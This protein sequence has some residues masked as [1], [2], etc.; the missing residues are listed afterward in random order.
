[1]SSVLFRI[2]TYKE[3]RLVDTSALRNRLKEAPVVPLVQ[4]DNPETAVKI[5]N[6][7]VAGGLTVIEV[8]LRTSAALECLKEN[9]DAALDLLAKAIELNAENQ[10]HAYHDPDF[11]FLRDDPEHAALFVAE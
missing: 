2:G 8:V 11:S 10:V 4:A 5:A 3:I 6:A 1:M 9:T 7:L